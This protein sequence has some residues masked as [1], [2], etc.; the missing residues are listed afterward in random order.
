MARSK[1]KA[2]PFEFRPADI[3][4]KRLPEDQWEPNLFFGERAPV[5]SLAQDELP[6][7]AD[8][9]SDEPREDTGPGSA[10]LASMFEALPIEWVTGEPAVETLR[11]EL[12][13]GLRY[14]GDL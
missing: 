11:F 10:A 1:R 3:E 8:Q 14:V 7:E 4:P 2:D 13:D 12:T 9:P 5:L 6:A